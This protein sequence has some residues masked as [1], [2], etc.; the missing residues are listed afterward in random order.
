MAGLA[1]NLAIF[2]VL[3][4][5]AA[6][7]RRRGGPRRRFSLFFYAYLMLGLILSGLVTKH[8]S[9]AAG[10]LVLV[11]LATVGRFWLQSFFYRH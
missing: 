5:V 1:I 9:A 3:V 8:A 2:I 6:H 4:G 7:T 10:L 11:V